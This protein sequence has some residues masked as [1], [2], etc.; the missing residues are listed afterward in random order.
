M[1]GK[2][3]SS[4]YEISEETCKVMRQPETKESHFL[5][6]FHS[7]SFP[8]FSRALCQSCPAALLLWVC[9]SLMIILANPSHLMCLCCSLNEELNSKEPKRIRMAIKFL[10]SS[11]TLSRFRIKIHWVLHFPFLFSTTPFSNVWRQYAENEFVY[12][13]AIRWNLMK[14]YEM[15]YVKQHIDLL[16]WYCR[17]FPGES[18][19]SFCYFYLF[20]QGSCSLKNK[21]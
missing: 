15:Y 11:S 3:F 9:Y 18:F 17:P 6:C 13:Y 2:V 7:S 10:W 16:N 5:F 21:H 8:S 20:S 12:K 1:N 19:A 4:F 14:W